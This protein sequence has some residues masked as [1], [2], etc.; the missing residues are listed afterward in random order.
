[1]IVDT[2][3]LARFLYPELKRVKLNLVAKH[4]G[5]SLENHHRAVDD[6]KATAEIF[7]ISI[8]KMIE[9]LNMNS[10][11]DLNKEFL[12]KMDI[13]KEKAHHVIIFAKTQV[14]MKNLYKLVSEAHI[15]NFQKH[16]RTR[17]SKLMEMRDGLLIGSACE[18]GEVY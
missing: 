14:G 7:L 6:A 16:P 2:V 9:E 13:K 3:P 5:V 1:T 15:D 18:A 4:L 17:K 11:H 12:E 10:L 8:K